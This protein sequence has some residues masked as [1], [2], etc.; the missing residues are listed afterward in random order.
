MPKDQSTDSLFPAIAD[1]VPGGARPGVTYA[2]ALSQNVL[3]MQS[4]GFK[5][6]T[7]IFEVEGHA[8]TLMH[9]GRPIGVDAGIPIVLID[10]EA[11]D[12]LGKAP[13]KADAGQPAAA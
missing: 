5:P 11:D 4:E 7:I 13:P 9:K 1:I 10:T 6:T 8:F 2:Y 12:L 3:K